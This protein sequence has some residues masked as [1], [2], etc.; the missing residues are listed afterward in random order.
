MLILLADDHTI[1]RRGL[2]QILADAFPASQFLEAGNA[3]EVLHLLSGRKCGLLV[4][5][6]TMPGRSGMD[7]LREAKQAYPQLPVVMLSMHPEEQYAV[8][9]LRAGASAFLNKDSAPEEL[10][11]AVKKVLSGGRYVSARLSEKLVAELGRDVSHAAHEHLSDREHEVLRMIA[12]GVSLTGIADRLHVS[13][14]TIS[15]HRTRILEKMAM[16]SNADLVRYALE[17]KL[18]E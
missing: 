5:D 8:R 2:R 11:M 14:K 15:T 18:I 10:V 17:H 12:S 16:E 3:A 4:L 7:V 1:V 9:A 6:V 13:V